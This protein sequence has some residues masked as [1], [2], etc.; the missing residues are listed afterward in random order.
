MHGTVNIERDGSS[1]RRRGFRAAN[2]RVEQILLAGKVE[3]LQIL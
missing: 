1:E 2:T 3:G